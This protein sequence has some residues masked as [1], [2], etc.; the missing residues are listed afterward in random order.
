[1]LTP[2]NGAPAC[3]LQIARAVKVCLRKKEAREGELVAEAVRQ[4]TQAVLDAV[5]AR[6][7]RELGLA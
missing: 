5:R 7:M 2:A 6:R 4:A 3:D 1:V